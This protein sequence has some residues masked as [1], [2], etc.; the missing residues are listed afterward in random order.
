MTDST[1]ARVRRGWRHAAMAL[2][3][4]MLACADGTGP[5]APPRTP[6]SISKLTGDNQTGIGGVPVATRL[7]VRVDDAASRAVP[8][9]VVTF[10]VSSGGGSIDGGTATT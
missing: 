6:A 4:L 8:G 3:A 10:T 1:M 5:L 2:A 9:A 7:S